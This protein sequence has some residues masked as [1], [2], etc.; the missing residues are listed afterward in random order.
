MFVRSLF[1]IW[2][3][4]LVFKT[5]YAE[6][7]VPPTPAPQGAPSICS[8]EVRYQW[9]R[10][11]DKGA[12]LEPQIVTFVSM[13]AKGAS[14]DEAKSELAKLLEEAKAR[15]LEVC[16][17]KHENLSGCVAAKMSS[18]TILLNSLGFRAREALQDAIIED[19]KG[20]TGSCALS[21]S[22]PPV[23]RAELQAVAPEAESKDEASKKG[24]KKK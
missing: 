12:P 19:C 9:S 6:E 15:A 5:A 4:V 22:E 11:D 17:A 23:C 24:D 10:R 21:P 7:A 18:N 1:T 20:Q 3:F 16:A 8:G 14:E 2:C 13:Q